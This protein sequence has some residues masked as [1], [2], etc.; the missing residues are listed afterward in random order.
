MYVVPLK[1]PSTMHLDNSTTFM[2]NIARQEKSALKKCD[3]FCVLQNVLENV[4]CNPNASVI[5][6]V[7][8]ETASRTM[9]SGQN[10]HLLTHKNVRKFDA[11]I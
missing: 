9:H 6:E 3:G 10:D 8:F 5:Y 1:F 7:S 11:K 2:S 4:Y